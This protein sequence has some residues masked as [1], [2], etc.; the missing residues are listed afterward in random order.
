[1]LAAQRG[2]ARQAAAAGHVQVEQH[3][4]GLRFGGQY[5]QHAGQVRRFPQAAF[6]QAGARRLEQRRAEQRVVV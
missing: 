6:G 5:Q 1:M 3:Q 4:V 2:Q